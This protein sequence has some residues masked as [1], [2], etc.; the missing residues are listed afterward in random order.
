MQGTG[1]AIAFKRV[2][3]TNKSSV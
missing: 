1:F 3:D 2:K